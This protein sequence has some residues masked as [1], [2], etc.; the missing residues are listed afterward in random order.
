MD[1]PSKKR[2]GQEDEDG[3]R[4]EKLSSS[5]ALFGEF[6]KVVVQ[7]DLNFGSSADATMVLGKSCQFIVQGD[8][9]LCVAQPSLFKSQVA[10][11]L[12]DI[13]PSIAALRKFDI[14][15]ARNSA[16]VLLQQVCNAVN[17]A[18]D[19]SPLFCCGFV[20][21]GS[22]VRGTCSALV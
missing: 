19:Y 16:V 17:A 10:S 6:S 11:C 21:V 4:R 8:V 9:H 14:A 2:K 20:E 1:G 5:C 3:I 12:L 7:G 15:T 18:L 22:T 13:W